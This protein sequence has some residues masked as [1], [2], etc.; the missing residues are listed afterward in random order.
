[1]NMKKILTILS[2]ALMIGCNGS[3]TKEPQASL[4]TDLDSTFLPNG[5]DMTD[6]F[7]T[8]TGHITTTIDVNGKPCVFL[9]DTGGGATLIDRSK[10]HK[11][12][13]TSSNTGD[14]A[15]GIGSKNSLV[16]TSAT[17][18]INGQDITVDDLY[19][20]DIT[21]INSEFR[22]NM[23]N[24]VEEIFEEDSDF[25][26]DDEALAAMEFYDSSDAME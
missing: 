19:L 7:K 25:S 24:E 15:A 11:F 13:L 4:S 10:K 12:G 14:Y 17:F 6:I 18:Q 2:V 8:R 1:M 20:M 26:N 5:C 3:N 22:K 16:R 9:I 21:Y 23:S